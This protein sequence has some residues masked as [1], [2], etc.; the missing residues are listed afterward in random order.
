MS[1][2]SAGGPDSV[3]LDGLVPGRRYR[4]DWKDD[5]IR[6]AFRAT[7]TFVDIR[8]EAPAEEGGKP[9]R[10]VRF[11]VRPRFGRAAIQ[12]IDAATLV[13]VVPI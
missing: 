12:P 6:R 8:E 2:G 3:D 7:G 9:R 11:Q 4:V 5:G 10:M 13:A 1:D